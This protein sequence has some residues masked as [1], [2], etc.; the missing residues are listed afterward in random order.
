[1]K[2]VIKNMVNYE[3]MNLV[4][5]MTDDNIPV[6]CEMVSKDKTVEVIRNITDGEVTEIEYKYQ[7]QP[8]ILVVYTGIRDNNTIKEFSDSIKGE[9]DKKGVNHILFFLPTDGQEK[10]ECI[11]P[12]LATEEQSKHIDKMITNIEKSFDIGHDLNDDY[13]DY[14]GSAVKPNKD[15]YN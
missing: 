4:Y 6:K 2:I 14:E 10:V 12:V 15:N 11:N 3:E 9:L 5:L 13:E 1:M 7:E 8:L